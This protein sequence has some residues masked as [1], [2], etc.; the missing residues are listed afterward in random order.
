MAMAAGAFRK[1]ARVRR[2][3]QQERTG[4]TIWEWVTVGRSGEHL[5]DCE[6][7]QIAAAYLGEILSAKKAE[8]TA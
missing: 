3:R 6:R 2:A 1:R 4:Q 7:F 8:V 5:W